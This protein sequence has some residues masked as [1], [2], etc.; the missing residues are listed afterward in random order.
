MNVLDL[1]VNELAD[2][3]T[4]NH[5]AHHK[6]RLQ[7]IDR[8]PESHRIIVTFNEYGQPLMK[9]GGLYTRYLGKI[10]RKGNMCPLSYK[11][12]R[13]MPDYYTSAIV[14]KVEVSNKGVII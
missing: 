14:R 3:E 11:D 12:W 13:M 5:F 6:M 4:G 2:S 7:D 9:A 8:L 10:A 1:L